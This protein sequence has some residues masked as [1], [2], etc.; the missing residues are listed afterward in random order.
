MLSFEAAPGSSTFLAA[1]IGA[2]YLVPAYFAG[3]V[4]ST[5]LDSKLPPPLSHDGSS[6]TVGEKIERGKAVLQNA[7]LSAQEIE[8]EKMNVATTG[9]QEVRALIRSYLDVAAP[10][11][12]RA[13]ASS[14]DEAA[15]ILKDASSF[16]AEQ[17]YDFVR[18]GEN[19]PSHPKWA[20]TVTTDIWITAA[21]LRRSGKLDDAAYG[22]VEAL[23]RTLRQ[24][25]APHASAPR[26]DESTPVIVRCVMCSQRLRLAPG[27]GGK[28]KCPSCGHAV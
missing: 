21:L 3:A 13:M 22:R 1:I 17:R 19:T 8:L 25:T 9:K 18:A 16:V 14:A 27:R 10:F 5:L 28:P 24:G 20:A 4:A 26:Q 15:T 12:E 7:T 2:G 11:V 6:S 23:V